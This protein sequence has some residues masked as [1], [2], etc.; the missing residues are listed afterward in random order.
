MW[1]VSL[2]KMSI[3]YLNCIAKP[4]QDWTSNFYPIVRLQK[5]NLV[6][7]SVATTLV[8]IR[9]VHLANQTLKNYHQ[10]LKIIR[11]Q[12]NHQFIAI[13]D[14]VPKKV[15]LSLSLTSPI[16][17]FLYTLQ[18]WWHEYELQNQIKTNRK[19]ND[20]KFQFFDKLC[21][22]EKER[23]DLQQY[24]DFIL[25]C[26]KMTLKILLYTDVKPLLLLV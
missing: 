6:C 23:K 8:F 13:V 9:F 10:D 1:K 20:Q 7:L 15:D 4:V 25:W 3:C 21:V 16:F 18:G 19:S 22:Q 5:Q 24:N 11:L 2:W 12:Q 26:L 14:C 17:L